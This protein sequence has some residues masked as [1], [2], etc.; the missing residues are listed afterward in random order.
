M[1]H[2]RTPWSWHTFRAIRHL[3]WKIFDSVEDET[4][5]SFST[6]FVF[7][8][9]QDKTDFKLC[10]CSVDNICRVFVGI[11]I[12]SSRRNVLFSQSSCSC[13]SF[14]TIVL[15]IGKMVL[16]NVFS[17]SSHLLIFEIKCYT[18]RSRGSFPLKSCQNMRTAVLYIPGRTCKTSV[19]VI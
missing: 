6:V 10:P 4:W 17:T 16:F 14:P 5:L 8:I 18:W 12:R 11:V 9:L 13:N 1:P 7:A 3:N 19:P 2:F 15:Q